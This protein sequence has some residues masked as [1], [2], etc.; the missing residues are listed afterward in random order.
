MYPWIHRRIHP[1]TLTGFQ[2]GSWQTE[3]FT[4]VP[5][6]HY[7]SLCVVQMR[8]PGSKE[9]GWL[10]AAALARKSRAGLLTHIRDPLA[11]THTHS[12]VLGGCCVASPSTARVWGSNVSRKSEF[13][14]H[15]HPVGAVYRSVRL[16]SSTC[17][18]SESASRRWWCIESL[19]P[20]SQCIHVSSDSWPGPR[21]CSPLSARTAGWWPGSISNMKGLMIVGWKPHP[22]YR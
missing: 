9:P 20:H 8:T 2:T 14:H 5:Q 22:S 13:T 12:S 16:N 17:A 4:Q 11:Y 19:F 1:H 6:I 18:V 10:V 7:I 21:S 3:S 15:H